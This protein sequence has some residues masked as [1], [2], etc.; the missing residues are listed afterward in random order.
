MQILAYEPALCVPILLGL[1][2]EM[3]TVLPQTFPGLAESRFH[4]HCPECAGPRKHLTQ[5]HLATVHLGDLQALRLLLSRQGF[6]VG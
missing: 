1:P 6:L 5:H 2:V 3:P 4:A